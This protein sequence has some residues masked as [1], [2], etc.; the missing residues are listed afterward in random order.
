MAYK[1][2]D[3]KS[4][5]LYVD[6]GVFFFMQILLYLMIKGITMAIMPVKSTTS[7]NR[8]YLVL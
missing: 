1:G 2:T 6:R 7:M 8:L 4:V 5:P 3:F